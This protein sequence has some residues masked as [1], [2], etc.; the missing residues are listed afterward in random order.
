MDTMKQRLAEQWEEVMAGV[1][2]GLLAGGT[3]KEITQEAAAYGMKPEDV[4]QIRDG[5][6]ERQ[7]KQ[8]ELER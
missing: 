1:R 8:E 5:L 7:Q 2:D 3:L 4:V 6:N